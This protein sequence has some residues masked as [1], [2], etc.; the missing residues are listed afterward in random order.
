MLTAGVAFGL[1]FALASIC[2]VWA[3]SKFNETEQE[4]DH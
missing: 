2:Y 1:I 4:G 3:S